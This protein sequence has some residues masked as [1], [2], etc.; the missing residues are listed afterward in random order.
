MTSILPCTGIGA[1]KHE[2]LGTRLIEPLVFLHAILFESPVIATQ[3]Y[4]YY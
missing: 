2:L 3:S 4:Y 1:K